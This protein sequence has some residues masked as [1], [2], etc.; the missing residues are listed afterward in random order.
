MH[1]L[2]TLDC[3]VCM[4]RVS[5]LQNH[6]YPMFPLVL[7]GRA[8]RLRFPGRRAGLRGARA[9]H[10]PPGGH[11]FS[12]DPADGAAEFEAS[13]CSLHQRNTT[14]EHQGRL[15]WDLF[16]GLRSRFCFFLFFLFLVQIR[17]FA[18]LQDFE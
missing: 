17:M 4:S 14:K 3:V 15:F 13:R 5:V 2:Y 7:L 9:M 6:G 12:D 8:V 18:E 11:A 10:R 1:V 16:F